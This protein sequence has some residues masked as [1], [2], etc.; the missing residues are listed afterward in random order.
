MIKLKD[1]LKVANREI[2]IKDGAYDILTLRYNYFDENVLSEKLLNSEIDIVDTSN[3]YII[4]YLK[5][6]V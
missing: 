2:V 4:V 3:G 5:D 6:E 1:F